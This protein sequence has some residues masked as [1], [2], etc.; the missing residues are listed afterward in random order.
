MTEERQ[1]N[2]TRIPPAIAD[3]PSGVLL[4]YNIADRN[5]FDQAKQIW[6]TEYAQ[7]RLKPVLLIGRDESS[8][9]G[10][11][12]SRRFTDHI[13]VQSDLKTTSG[14]GAIR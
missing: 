1:R 6:L 5:S 10:E 8:W 13:C 9:G 12:R 2:K 3:R 4:T 11:M 14:I 7:R